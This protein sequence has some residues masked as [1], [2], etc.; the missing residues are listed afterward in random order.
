M[1]AEILRNAGIWIREFDLQTS[2]NA[3]SLTMTVDSQECTTFGSGARQY[4][5][6]LPRV[7]LSATGYPKDDTVD[8]ALFGLTGLTGLTVTVAKDRAIAAIAYVGSFLDTSYQSVYDV[9]NVRSFQLDGELSDRSFGRGQVLH[10]GT[11]VT[12]T[13]T[14]GAQLLRAITANKNAYATLHVTAKSGTA[15]VFTGRIESDDNVG[16]TTPVTRATFTVLTNVVGSQLITIAGPITDTYW[17]AAWTIA[18]TTPSFN[19]A[20]ALGFEEPL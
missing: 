20:T 16:F 15:P 14:G 6:G 11:A 12:T 10:V 5:M 7:P 13:G 19:F 17:R 3:V 9:A 1:A 8:E 18:G 2:L 4:A